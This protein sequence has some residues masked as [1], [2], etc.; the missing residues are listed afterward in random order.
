[1]IRYRRS[2]RESPNERAVSIA[3]GS[4][5]R[6]PYI[7]WTRSGQNAPNAARKTSLFKL[8]PRVRKRTGMSAADGIGRRNSIGT[9]NARAAVSLDPSRIPIGTASTVAIAS[10]SAQPRTVCANAVQNACVCTIVQSSETADDMGGRSR[11]S[12][13]PVRET[14]SQT[15]SADA[16]ETT[17][18]PISSDRVRWRPVGWTAPSPNGRKSASRGARCASAPFLAVAASPDAAM[19]DV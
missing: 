13:S 10:P 5:S 15:T 18:N 14:S 11:R 17:V 1:V 16:I 6:T 4:T 8:I 12:I 9:R 2:K 19:P 3:T 7:V